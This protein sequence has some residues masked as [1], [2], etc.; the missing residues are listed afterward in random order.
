MNNEEIVFEF[1]SD[2]FGDE[3]NENLSD[4][5]IMSAVSDLNEMC[6]AINEYFQIDEKHDDAEMMDFDATATAHSF[7]TA[8][9]DKQKRRFRTG[10]SGRRGGHLSKEG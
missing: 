8:E 3:L 7:N 2:Y 6:S 5:D 9:A 10:K 1:L 4:D